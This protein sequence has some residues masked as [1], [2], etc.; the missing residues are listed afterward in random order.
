MN[1]RVPRLSM[2]GRNSLIRADIY[3]QRQEEL[4]LHITPDAHH[5][6]LSVLI[7]MAM[8]D[9]GLFK[10]F[11]AA[12]QSQYEWRRNRNPRNPRRS[13][14][15]LIIQNDAISSL[16]K[17]LAQPSAHLDDGLIMSVLH[18]MVADVSFII[19]CSF[20]PN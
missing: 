4:C 5:P 1:V 3:T 2:K 15:M 11:L 10:S 12:A 14:A 19:Q 9:A 6:A 20:I 16:Q 8:Q 7:P 18:I 17:R 13:Q